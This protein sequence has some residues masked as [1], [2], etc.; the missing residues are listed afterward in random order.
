MNVA[1]FCEHS[2]NAFLIRWDGEDIRIRVD[3]NEKNLL[4]RRDARDSR[5]VEE[6]SAWEG[7]G[8]DAGGVLG[9]G[10]KKWAWKT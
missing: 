10:L 2:L 7:N 8:D 6:E 4:Y 1:D 3:E 9:N 5:P